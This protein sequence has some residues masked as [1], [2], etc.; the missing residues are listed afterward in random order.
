MS[1]KVPRKGFAF[2]EVI[3][4]IGL[5][6]L[7]ILALSLLS[8]R[9]LKSGNESNDRIAAAAV[10][11][12]IL[13][14]VTKAAQTDANFWDNDHVATPYEE[15]NIRLGKLDYNYQIFA[16]TVVDP[17]GSVL[18]NGLQKNRLKRVTIILTWYNTKNQD[19]Q[20]YGKLKYSATRLVN[21]TGLLP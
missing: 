14:K 19:R 18:G 9:I 16:Q 2:V 4:A 11:D 1:S 7:V 13:S 17:T 3:L 20:G 10:A 21:E 6:G 15:K 5:L 12:T 8:L